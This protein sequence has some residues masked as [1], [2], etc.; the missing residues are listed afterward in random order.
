MTDFDFFKIFKILCI[1]LCAVFFL[2]ACGSDSAL[3]S[4][5]KQTEESAK[6]AGADC[7]QQSMIKIF[8]EH[9]GQVALKSYKKLTSENLLSLMML[10]FTIWMAFQILGHVSA[11]SPESMGEFW[12]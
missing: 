11:S 10:A 3:C 9:T 4:D 7:W 2:T 5:E 6:G 1:A 12:T 8:Y